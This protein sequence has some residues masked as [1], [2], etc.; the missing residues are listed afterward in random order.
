MQG[1]SDSGTISNLSSAEQH[2]L[3]RVLNSLRIPLIPPTG[4][5]EGNWLLGMNEFNYMASLIKLH[6]TF[7]TGNFDKRRFENGLE[8]CLNEVQEG[9]CRLSP[10][11][12]PG[13][14]MIVDGFRVS[15]K[16]EG[17]RTIKQNQVHISKWMEMGSADWSNPSNLVDAFLSHSTRYDRVVVL[18]SLHGNPRNINDGNV[19]Y[20]LLELPLS[21]MR[22][23]I[24]S[25]TVRI[26]ES[27]QTPN[28]VYVDCEINGE[29][30]QFYFDG[31]G[32]QKLQIKKF[33]I[34]ECTVIATWSFTLG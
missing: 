25:G 33:P 3:T 27:T 19:L 21:A 28:P 17:A 10:P 30:F 1:E 4:L 11:G 8:E 7:S 34:S 15:C 12:H 31:G 32:E 29:E 13:A 20:Q 14:D 22:S 24:Q 5:E 16:T 18:R 26:P 6:H 9:R 2:L 23:A